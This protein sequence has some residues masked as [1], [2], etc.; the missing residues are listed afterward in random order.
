MQMFTPIQIILVY[1]LAS[2]FSFAKQMEIQSVEMHVNKLYIQWIT[3][4]KEYN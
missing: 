1:G 3:L 4:S 2:Q